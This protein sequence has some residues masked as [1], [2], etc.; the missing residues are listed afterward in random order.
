MPVRST[1]SSRPTAIA[2]S[3]DLCSDE[4]IGSSVKVRFVHAPA[5]TSSFDALAGDLLDL[6]VGDRLR[7]LRV[8]R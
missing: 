4:A 1:G 6:V 8:R 2:S 7:L 5:M 3:A